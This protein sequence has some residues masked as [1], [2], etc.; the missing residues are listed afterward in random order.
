MTALSSQEGHGDRICL[1]A[2]PMD[3]GIGELCTFFGA[4]LPSVREMRL[5]RRKESKRTYLAFLTFDSVKQ[6][7]LFFKSYNGRAVSFINPL[8]GLHDELS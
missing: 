4:F 3:V 6:G 7:A 8:C 2:I 5:V 1:L